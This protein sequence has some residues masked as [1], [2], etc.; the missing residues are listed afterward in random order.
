MQRQ[1]SLKVTN[2]ASFSWGTLDPLTVLPQPCLE[3]V[4]YAKQML[5]ILY[6]VVM[7]FVFGGPFFEGDNSGAPF[8]RNHPGI[9]NDCTPNP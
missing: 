1:I 3:F 2:A 9:I 5:T 6:T 4:F 8:Q 7:E